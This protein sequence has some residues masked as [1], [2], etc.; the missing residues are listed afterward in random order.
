MPQAG[1]EPEI[2]E[3]KRMQKQALDCAATDLG[4]NNHTEQTI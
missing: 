4:Y 2:P 1:F 3:S